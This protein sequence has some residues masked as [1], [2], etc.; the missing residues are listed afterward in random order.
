[1]PYFLWDDPMTVGEVRHRL[2]TASPPERD[3]LLGKILREARDTDV[4]RFTTPEYVASRF[5]A[6]S[7]H[8]GRRRA[9]WEFL[10]RRWYE[11]GLLEHE[12]A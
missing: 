9:F 12:P 1:M 6:L 5:G 11:E 2:A 8:L 10:L 7:R 4:W 3:R